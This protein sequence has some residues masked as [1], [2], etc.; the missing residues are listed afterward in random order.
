MTQKFSKNSKQKFVLVLSGKGGVGKSTVSSFL[1][2]KISQGKKTLLLDFDIC[3]PSMSLCFGL[4]GKVIKDKNSFRPLKYNNNL[5]ILSFGNVLGEEDVVIWRGP[6]KRV[7]LE[8]MYNSI[9]QMNEEGEFIYERVVIDTPPGISE[10]HEFLREK[11]LNCKGE[12]NNDTDNSNETIDDSSKAECLAVVVTTSQN[13]ALN[14]TQRTLD[15][16]EFSEIL[17]AGIIQNMSYILCECCDERIYMYGKNGG[18]LLAKE[19][20][21]EYLG[22]IPSDSKMI[23]AVQKGEFAKYCENTGIFDEITKNLEEKVLE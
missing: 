19:Y 17:V 8:L 13:I 10:E 22:E 15:F 18:E 2:H 12:T 7:F 3:G 21:V 20:A 11:L 23:E 4:K 14:D 6:K 9:H 5:D 16:C 1:S